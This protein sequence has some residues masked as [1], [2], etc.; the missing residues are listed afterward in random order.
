MGPAPSLLGLGEARA[1]HPC[2]HP[3]VGACTASWT[4][5]RRG[6]SSNDV[7]E[8]RSFRA[9]NAAR[10]IRR[11]RVACIA[12]GHGTVNVQAAGKNRVRRVAGT[13]TPSYSVNVA[14]RRRNALAM[15]LTDDSDM[16]RAAIT[17]DSNTP[18]IG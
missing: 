5:G 1:E 13:A 18:M 11:H 16:A 10:Y 15:T 4:H 8:Q 3:H 6:S 17:G 7:V 12:C 14:N 9:A 2:S